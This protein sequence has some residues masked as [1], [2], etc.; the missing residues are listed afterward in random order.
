MKYICITN[1]LKRFEVICKEASIFPFQ[2][3]FFFFQNP[4]F[5]SFLVSKTFLSDMSVKGGGGKTLARQ[6]NV[7]YFCLKKMENVRY[8]VTCKN[9][10][11]N[12]Q[13]FVVGNLLKL[14]FNIFIHNQIIV[15]SFQNHPFQDIF[16][17][18]TYIF[19][20]V[21]NT[22][23]LIFSPLKPREGGGSG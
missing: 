22:F 14:S 12:F 21:K 5:H 1:I 6:E 3:I 15:S 10:Q 8:V 11:I 20:L 7:S 16:V 18:K 9:M 17:Y 23:L 4:P 13:K 19:I 2:P